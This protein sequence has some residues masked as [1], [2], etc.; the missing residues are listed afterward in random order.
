MMAPRSI[1]V[2]AIY[3]HTDRRA[4]HGQTGISGETPWCHD[5]GPLHGPGLEGSAAARDLEHVLL[6]GPRPGR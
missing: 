2:D 4:R 1:Y 6:P 3:V 5:A